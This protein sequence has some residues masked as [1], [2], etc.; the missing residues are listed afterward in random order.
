MTSIPQVPR[1]QAGGRLAIQA[2]VGLGGVAA[3]SWE[4]IWQLRSSLALGVSARGAAITLA[5]TMGGMALGSVAFGRLLRSR[6]IVDPQRIYGHLE[7]FIGFCGLAMLGGFQGLEWLDGWLFGFWPE[8]ASLLHAAGILLVLGP[9]AAAMGATV[10]TFELLARQHHTSLSRLYAINVA[11]AAVGVLLLTFLVLP[12]LG[13]WRTC[14]LVASINFA[15]FASTRFIRSEA[16]ALLAAP[17]PVEAAG[18]SIESA[19]SSGLSGWLASL[20]VVCT[21]FATL[22][23]EVAWFRSFRAAFQDTADTFAIILAAV[24]V[25]LAI[26][27][28][29]VP[30]VRRSRLTPGVLLAYAGVLILIATPLVERADLMAAQLPF[31][32]SSPEGYPMMLGMRLLMALG[33]FGPIVVMLG[34]LLPWLLDEFRDP[35]AAGRLYALNTA[36]AVCGSLVAA[37]L[38]LPALGFA[39]T[40]WGIGGLVLAV[41]FIVQTE[42]RWL[43]AAAGCA[44]LSVAVMQTSS[45]GRERILGP[46]LR[47]DHRVVAFDEG[48]DSTVSVVAIDDLRLLVIDGFLA[49]GQGRDIEE[50]MEWMGRL[51]MLL[52]PDPGRALVICFGTGQTAHA[53]RDE[54]P[55]ALDI[56]ELSSA[57]LGFAGHFDMNYG[58]LNDE[59]VSSVVMDGRAWLRRTRTRYDVIT[60]EPMPPYFAGVNALY[61][62]EF[63]AA[64]AEKLNPGGVVAQWLPIRAMPVYYAASAAAAFQELFPDS[65]LWLDRYGT[66]ILLG[67]RESGGEPLGSQWPGLAR[68]GRSGVVQEKDLSPR[69]VLDAA[70]LSRYAALGD[71]VTDDNQLLTYG[72]L[73]VFRGASVI[74]R[75]LGTIRDLGGS[76]PADLAF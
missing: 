52:H 41:A 40:S 33:L 68:V 57:V 39:R 69:V 2:V 61:S 71:L 36:G 56:V 21:G 27:A 44:A 46:F 16:P 14:L 22:A 58:V 60:L 43:T 19:R 74:R 50:Y 59:R 63:Y 47:D 11:G 51:P 8:L 26:A 9:A 10:P 15:V 17:D 55:A 49:T 35:E 34:V 6:S 72:R 12:V 24:L 37:W 65:I 73:L 76:V 42:R 67:R 7:L 4:V 1:S 28:R 30:W 25:P 29:L 70:G 53:V 18:T 20:I 13:V 54:Q 62:R 32:A 31:P 75:N 48:P 23:L 66:G 64:M 5:A 3:L 38:L 45:I